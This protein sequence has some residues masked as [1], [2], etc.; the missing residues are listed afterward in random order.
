MLEAGA[1]IETIESRQG[2]K[3]GCIEEVALS[4]NFISKS[5]FKELINSYPKNDYSDYLRKLISWK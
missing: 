2:L 4:K 5:A 3:I 1:F